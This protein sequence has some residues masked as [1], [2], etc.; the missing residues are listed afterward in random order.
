MPEYAQPHSHE[1]LNYCKEIKEGTTM[2][3]IVIIC[4]GDFG[5][6]LTW[7]IEGI[8]AAGPAYDIIGFL[9][10]A[11]DKIGKTFNG[12][13]CLGKTDMLAELSEKYDVCAVIATQDSRF[14]RK[15]AEENPGFDK[16]ETLIHP[17][18]NISRTSKLGKGCIVCAN[19][20]ISVNTVIGDHCLFNLGVTIGHDC[21]IGDY[22]SVM[23]GTVI[24]GH[25]TVKPS[26]YFGTNSTVVPGI[27]VG[28]NSKIGAGSLVVRNVRD[29]VTVMGV[30]AKTVNIV[31]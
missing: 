7:L 29:N 21:N 3:K 4:A 16:W 27:S 6:E 22:A 12:Y 19:C 11:P 31:Q 13:E 26:S 23:T 10:D 15:F 30:P 2:K 20:N 28:E 9:D 5:R 8:N 17:S 14:R 18:A 24:S 25:V 1:R